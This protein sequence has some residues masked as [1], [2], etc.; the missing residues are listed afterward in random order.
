[1]RIP[2]GLLNARSVCNKTLEVSELITD[3]MIDI[4]CIC[5][6]WLHGD[7][8]DNSILPE[9]TPE[10]Y[11]VEHRAR[12]GR[13]GG[14][15]VVFR[16][17]IATKQPDRLCFESFEYLD[18]VLQTNPPLRLV[19]VYRPPN[20][21]GNVPF[22]RF[23][24]EMEQLFDS[25][26]MCG[27][28]LMI[29]GDFNIHLNECTNQDNQ[30]RDLLASYAL[31]QLVHEPTHK[32]GHTLDLVMIRASSTR[33]PTTSV[34][35]KCLSDHFLVLCDLPLC[36]PLKQMRSV[37]YRKIKNIERDLFIEDIRRSDL[38]TLAAGDLTSESTGEAARRYDSVLTALLDI[39]A[40]AKNVVIT[41]RQNAA[42]YSPELRAAKQERRR[43]EDLWRKTKLQVHENAF[44]S[45]KNDYNRRVREARS[46][47]LQEAIRENAD[48]PRHL[49]TT[50]S[51]L[52]GNK[53]ERALP[54]GRSDAQLAQ[55]FATFFMEKI[56]LIRDSIDDLASPVDSL[57][58][59]ESS[60][61][62]WT[63]VSEAEVERII[64]ASPT[65]S[66][67]LDPIPTDLLKDCLQ[68]LLPPITSIINLSLST[69]VVPPNFK[70]AR[71][72]PSLKKPSLDHNQ[73]N[74][75]RPVSNLPFLSKI[76]EKVVL[77]RLSTYLSANDLHERNQSA[78]K[79][80][81]S[82]ETALLRMQNDILTS[83][84]NRRPCLLALLDL[85]AAFDT[86]DHELL[87]GVLSKQGITGTLLEWFRSYLIGRQ[88]YVSIGT[89]NSPLHA[90]TSG[91]PQGSVLGPVLFNT[92]TA[93]LG[94]LLERHGMKYQ[95][96]ADDA[97]VYLSF[98]HDQVADA[99]DCM[100]RCIH[101]VE[102]WMSAM[103]LKMNCQKTEA[104][105]LASH[106]TAHTM[107][108]ASLLQTG[109]SDSEFS[110]VVEVYVTWVCFWT[111]P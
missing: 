63:P 26:I 52:I 49:F 35:N 12:H 15:A 88:Q 8:R 108:I 76:L 7:I 59:C 69:G 97:S 54:S 23:I 64:R 56:R 30:F 20:N 55:E 60:L 24:A 34:L 18:I 39:H 92:Y 67:P 10:G 100:T 66:C 110:R 57:L 81:H 38:M 65:K 99:F 16:Q 4:C 74:N 94:S 90:L 25:L 48:N 79:S 1:M 62:C 37:T 28:E 77:A 105:V 9:L 85:S 101:D 41:D 47:Y 96:Y 21:H 3:E 45:V 19:T 89:Q 98:E 70:I 43:A 2:I 68:I 71:V 36:R 31:E 106:H 84:G 6:T 72:I 50:T 11:T 51:R 80:F 95:L 102:K 93:S 91:V 58:Q 17:E 5:E 109:D 78:Y 27:G 61:D 40:P 104:I 75:F 46:K 82:T 44:R 32:A 29:V 107:G 14:V 87:L 13:G 33:R 53:K 22:G 111:A 86:V 83:L 42:W 103:K 73:L